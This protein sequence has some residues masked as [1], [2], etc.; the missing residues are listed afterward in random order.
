MLKIPRCLS[1]RVGELSVAFSS[2]YNV[3]LELWSSS[4]TSSLASRFLEDESKTF[5]GRPH[6]KVDNWGYELLSSSNLSE[7]KLKLCVYSLSSSSSFSVKLFQLC[8]R[9]KSKNNHQTITELHKNLIGVLLT[10]LEV[11]CKMLASYDKALSSYCLDKTHS[12]ER[13]TLW[14]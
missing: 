8:T 5:P 11:V 10:R 12:H 9:S 3:L 6:N 7:A 2:N 1:W 13:W 14:S 4:P